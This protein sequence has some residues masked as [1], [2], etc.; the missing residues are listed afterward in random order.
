MSVKE[1]VKPA[2]P[3]NPVSNAGN[4]H[5][6]KKKNGQGGVVL[7]KNS[8]ADPEILERYLPN[9]P[10]ID[11]ERQA[12][13]ESHQ[14]A[15]LRAIRP[16]DA[17]EEIWAQDFIDFTWEAQRL[18]RM[19][20]ALIQAERI[21]AVESLIQ[22]FDT[23][24]PILDVLPMSRSA[25]TAK[26]W[27]SG[28]KDAVAFVEK[29]MADHNLDLE[30]IMA[31]AMSLRLEEIE[32]IDRLISFYG[33]RRDAAIQQLEKWRERSPRRVCEVQDAIYTDVEA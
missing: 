4:S 5:S 18:S 29:L 1:K 11:G 13:Y 22:K 33:Y 3:G 17:V 32:R 20:L 28:K 26:A 24:D 12:D 10:L 9:P 2:K 6:K 30:N 8:K 25:S 31:E 23:G 14:K 16:K 27:S 21:K 7:H 15:C 19:K